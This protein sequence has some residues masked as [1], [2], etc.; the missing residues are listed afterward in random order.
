MKNIWFTDKQRQSNEL[1]C[2]QVRN[3]KFINNS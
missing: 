2:D 3:S 1:S